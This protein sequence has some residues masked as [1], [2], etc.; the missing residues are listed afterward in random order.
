M[1][2]FTSITR[3]YISKAIVLGK[4]I[5]RK[6]PNSKFIICLLERSVPKEINNIEFID[7]IILAQDIGII[8]FEKF[9][10][11]HSIVEGCTAVKGNFFL[12]LL[13]KFKNE[14]KFVY[15]DPDIM[16]FNKLDELECL[17]DSNE[18]ILTPHL[19]DMESK[20]E[21]IIDNE[22]GILKHGVYNLGFLA[23]RRGS[24]S[25][26]FLEWWSK[27]LN[28]YCYAENEK[29]IYTDQ[30]WI[31]L[32]PGIFNTYILKGH[33]YNLAPWNFSKRKV[34]KDMSSNFLVDGENL[35]FL[36]FSGFDK[37]DFEESVEKYYG[38]DGAIVEIINIYKQSLD[39]MNIF[40]ISDRWDF[41]Y[42]YSG[43]K[44]DSR[45]RML[46][47]KYTDFF[48]DIDNPYELS[49][50]SI[51]KLESFISKNEWDICISEIENAYGI[52]N[53]EYLENI[54][55][56]INY[57]L[58]MNYGNLRYAIWGTGNSGKITKKLIKKFLP[59]SNLIGYIDKYKVGYLDGIK[60]YSLDELNELECDNIIIC[61]TYGRGFAE[62][63]LQ[64]KYPD[65]KY[66]YGYGIVKL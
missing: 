54:K 29:G 34:T 48:D 10:F 35:Y 9:V 44:V 56:T 52:L 2:I 32:V 53:C 7:Q 12:Y 43:E 66:F 25:C 42:Y 31:D 20:V 46:Y 50:E 16:V 21:D 62:K 47:R 8:D 63:F 11:K 5:K 26:R 37:G 24:E 49:N 38:D 19:L 18:I 6:N 45:S 65:K 59:Q 41:D 23:I 51:L 36:H 14:D 22:I 15:L 60:I 1:I 61:A 4:S 17:L 33:G 58:K 30:K 64:S 40:K 27:R 28:M 55:V 3:N 13:K 57:F 39:E